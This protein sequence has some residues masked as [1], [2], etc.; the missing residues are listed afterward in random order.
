MIRQVLLYYRDRYEESLADW[1][2][3]LRLVNPEL[4]HPR[5]LIKVFELLAEAGVI[6]LHKGE[7]H[8]TKG[9]DTFFL[10]APFT[11]ALTTH[12]GDSPA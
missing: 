6:T 7:R 11:A 3:A 5:Q 1:F 9:D 12:G 4:K 8:Y 2:Y 10:G